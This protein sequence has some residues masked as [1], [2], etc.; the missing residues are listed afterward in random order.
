MPTRT[1]PWPAGTPCWIDLGT[2]DPDAARSFYAAVLDWTYRDTGPDSGG[3]LFCLKDGHE[4]AGLGPQQD[5]ADPPRWTTYFATDDADATAA[6]VTEAGG[7]VLAPPMDVGPAGRMAIV[8]DPQGSPFGLWQAGTTTGV[9]VFN[10]PGA[11]AWNE[12][13]VDDPAAAQEFYTAV[14]GFAWEEIPDAGGYS[15]F[16]TGDR[17]LGGLGGVV[18]GLP[19]GWSNAFSVA[20]TDAAVRAVE[21]GG[22]K[23]LMPAEDTPYGRVAVVTDPWRAAFSVM[24]EPAG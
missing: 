12:A 5:P 17:P 23:V 6:R 19:R 13:A 3:Y 1:T 18:E 14:F 24:Q 7:T 15:T 9:Q 8:A 20:D 16:A 21:T 11:L 2:P 4:A 22:G 10:E